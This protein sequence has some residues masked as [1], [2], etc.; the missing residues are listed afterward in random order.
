MPGFTA[1]PNEV[2]DCMALLTPAEFKVMLS[3][4]RLIIGYEDYRSTGRRQISIGDLQTAT[5]LS[6]QG[7]I[8]TFESILGTGLLSKE[9]DGRSTV[10]V[11][12]SV[13][14]SGK[15]V[16]NS[17]DYHSQ[18]SVPKVVNS[19]DQNTGVLKK[20]E[21]ITTN[22][23][24]DDSLSAVYTAYQNEISPTMTP[25]ISD[26]INAAFDE[27]G[28]EPMVKAI[29]IASSNG[30]RNWAYIEGILKRWRINGYQDKRNNGHSN[31]TSAAAPIQDETGGY[32]T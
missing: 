1:V 14:Q 27:F 15:E 23:N 25:L 11:V 21:N 13:D 6:R 3:I 20:K 32:Y 12:N 18:L 10:W 26:N 16:V 31:G 2:F 8:N 7:V 28:M 29:N 4:Y 17:V 9:T 24:G 30:A 19:V 22:T 5:N